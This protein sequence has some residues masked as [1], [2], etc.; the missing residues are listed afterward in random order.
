MADVVYQ[1]LRV[2]NEPPRSGVSKKIEQKDNLLQMYVM[3]IIQFYITTIKFM[4]ILHQ[5]FQIIFQ[6]RN[7]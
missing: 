4:F 7:T 1:V 6:Q 2:D 5:F 3:D